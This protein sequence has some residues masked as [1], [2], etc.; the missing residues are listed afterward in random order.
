MAFEN[1][2]SRQASRE[3]RVDPSIASSHLLSRYEIIFISFFMFSLMF[4]SKITN[5]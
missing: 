2:S 4:L 5:S 1:R 3:V